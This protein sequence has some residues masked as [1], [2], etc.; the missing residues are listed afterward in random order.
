MNKGIARL[1]PVILG[2]LVVLTAVPLDPIGTSALEPNE[3]NGWLVGMGFLVGTASLETKTGFVTGWSGGVTPQWRFGR[4]IVDDRLLLS[5]DNKQW[6]RE[7]GNNPT[8]EPPPGTD[9]VKYQVNTQVF[10]LQLTAFPGN[11]DNLWGGLYFNAGV[12]PAVA[13]IDSALV[14]TL[15]SG[16]DPPEYE[17]YEWGVGFYAGAGYEFRFLPYAAAGLSLNYIYNNIDEVYVDK[18][19]VWATAFTLNWYFK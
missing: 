2:L 6:T 12:G 7:W 3:R 16:E 14:D 5:I 13:R 15:G 4:M 18:G 9:Y 1:S 19:R 17:V 8:I 11:P 10:G